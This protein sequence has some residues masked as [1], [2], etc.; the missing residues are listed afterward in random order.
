MY[1]GRYIRLV[2]VFAALALGGCTT[3]RS[4]VSVDFYKISGQTTADLDREIERKG[5]KTDAGRHAVAV[6]RIRMVPNISYRRVSGGCVISS[7]Q[8]GVKAKVTLPTWTGRARAGK[9]LGQAW[10]NIDRYTR[11]HE[12]VHVAIAFRFARD[13]EATL[14]VLPPASDCREARKVAGELIR[15]ALEEHDRTQKQFDA[16]EQERFA[17][18]SKRKRLEQS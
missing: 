3:S 18:F 11:M 12:A 14:K 4:D 9:K 16:D 8:V 6:A 15:V 17:K 2:C 1:N 7:A 5:P 13:I 10:D